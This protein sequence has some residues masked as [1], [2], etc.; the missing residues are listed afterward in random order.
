MLFEDDQVTLL[1]QVL[2]W[3]DSQ[4]LTLTWIWTEERRSLHFCVI[5]ADGASQRTVKPEIKADQSLPFCVI[6]ADI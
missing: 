6:G 3:N 2:F 4:D 5:M 1:L